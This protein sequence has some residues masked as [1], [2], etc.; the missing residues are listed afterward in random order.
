[1]DTPDL[2][3]N[4]VYMDEYVNYLVQNLGDATTSTGIQGYALDNEPVLWNDTHPLLHSEEVTNS[5]LISKSIE[6]ASVVK[7]ID[8]NAEVY[9]P[10]FWGM[11]PCITIDDDDWNAVSSQ[12]DW[13]IAYYLEQ[14]AHAE[15]ET[16]T[17][18]LDV[19]DMHYYAQDCS[20][21]EV[22][23]QAARSLYDSDY[24]KDSWLQPWF[25]GYFPFLT[26][27]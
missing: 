12:Y 3:D 17:R 13:Y 6:L 9:G 11:L 8:P 26:R 1:M 21:E 23:L 7:E 27:L 10:S 2:T 20:T 14:M 16:G 25:G 15:E 19:L 24:Q 5:E 18:L 4:V 22:I